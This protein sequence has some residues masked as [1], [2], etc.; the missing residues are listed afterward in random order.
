MRLKD[1]VEL[2]RRASFDPNIHKH[3]NVE[4]GLRAVVEA[5][6]D[7]IAQMEREVAAVMTNGVVSGSGIL[8]EILASDGEVKAAGA[9]TRKDEVGA[10]TPASSPAAAP[11]CVWANMAGRNTYMTDCGRYFGPYHAGDKE[12]GKKC[13]GCGKPISFKDAAR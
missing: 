8:D 11:V 4:Q 13:H 7:E 3:P 10:R 12:P 9:S 5:L 1:I 6:R 2:Y